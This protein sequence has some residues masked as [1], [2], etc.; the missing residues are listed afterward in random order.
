MTKTISIGNVSFHIKVEKS[1]KKAKNRLGKG[2]SGWDTALIQ[3]NQER[4]VAQLHKMY[5]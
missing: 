5:Y 4:L 1:V 3:R 2:S